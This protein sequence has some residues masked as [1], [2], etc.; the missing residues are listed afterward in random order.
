MQLE[1]AR[2]PAGF[3]FYLKSKIILQKDAVY[4]K[5]NSLGGSLSTKQVESL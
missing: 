2:T 4:F 3:P 5:Y 1:Q